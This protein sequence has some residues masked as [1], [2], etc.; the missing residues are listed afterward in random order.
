MRALAL[1]A[2]AAALLAGCGANDPLAA[3]EISA[4]AQQ[5]AEAG[6]SRIEISGTD[7][8]DSFSMTGVA[9]YDGQ[10]THLTYSGTEDGEQHDGELVLAGDAF[11]VRSDAF[12]DP[13][14]VAAA[15]PETRQRL[16]GKR[17]LSFPVPFELE[18]S[19]DQLVFPFPLVDPSELL[20]TF[21]EVDGE[22]TRLGEKDVRGIP[23]DGYRLELDLARLVERAPA[24]RRQALEAELER[25]AVK[26]IPVEVWIDDVGRAR[27]FV[28]ELEEV[29]ATVDFF[30]FGVAVDV[31]APPK[32]EVFDGAHFFLTEDDVEV[33][34]GD[35]EEI[36]VQTIEEDE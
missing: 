2:A 19:L 31:Q 25:R 10:R 23:T 8:E 27:R 14:D 36:P 20:R 1:L 4:A 21:Q 11:Y 7:G 32:D 30:D 5:T 29:P 24:Q 3:E 15:P 26:T 18:S 35:Y 9:D 16:E 34:S 28:I 22:P 13:A 33:G 6:S 17:W 12:L